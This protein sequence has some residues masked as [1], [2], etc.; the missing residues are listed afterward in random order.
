MSYFENLKV[1]SDIPTT[2]VQVTT[3]YIEIINDLTIL[4]KNIRGKFGFNEKLLNIL[5]AQWNDGY[6][7]VTAIDG[8]LKHKI[9]TVHVHTE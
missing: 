4:E 5:Y 3:K 9:G 2:H 7:L 6:D 8:G 1:I